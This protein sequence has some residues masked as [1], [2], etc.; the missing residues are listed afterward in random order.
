MCGVS[1]MYS[2]R[3]GTACAR[4]QL[5][6]RP[7]QVRKSFFEPREIALR[8]FGGA[9]GAARTGRCPRGFGSVTRS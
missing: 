6:P 2:E 7:K 1:E 8:A 4:A 3:A 9:F 5:D